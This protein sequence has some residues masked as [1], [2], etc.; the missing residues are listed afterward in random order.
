MLLGFQSFIWNLICSI[1]V[2]ILRMPRSS[3]SV[4]RIQEVLLQYLCQE[5]RFN[6]CI[7][8]KIDHRERFKIK[9][10]GLLPVENKNIC[11]EFQWLT[12]AACVFWLSGITWA[13]ANISSP[14]GGG[15][16]RPPHPQSGTGALF[17]GA[18]P[19]TATAN[20]QT[21][22]FLS[23]WDLLFKTNPTKLKCLVRFGLKS[24]WVFFFFFNDCV[25]FST[26]VVKNDHISIH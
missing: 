8:L 10:M 9:K 18:A 26:F 14:A 21:S 24:I 2:W 25:T 11:G 23:R 1:E 22:V 6:L 17:A 15:Q 4:Q 20:Y 16:P 19:I 12:A 13:A 7:H 3:Q 5:V